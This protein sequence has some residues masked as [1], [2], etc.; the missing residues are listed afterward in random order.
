MRSLSGRG[1]LI[2]EYG[3][4]FRSSYE[5]QQ[6]R[7]NKGKGAGYL[8]A[9]AYPP[10]HLKVVVYTPPSLLPCLLEITVKTCFSFVFLSELVSTLNTS[11]AA[12]CFAHLIIA[13]PVQAA[14]V[15]AV[16]AVP[17]A[18]LCSVLWESESV[19]RAEAQTTHGRLF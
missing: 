1:R 3:S 9:L 2:N 17:Q 13:P 19:R 16:T 14:V 6:R 8:R 10:P 12:F 4:L 18:V 15:S 11:S 5:T 7:W